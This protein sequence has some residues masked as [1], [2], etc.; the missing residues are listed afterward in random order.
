[1]GDCRE[2]AAGQLAKELEEQYSGADEARRTALFEAAKRAASLLRSR[3]T[4]IGFW[5]AGLALFR[6]VIPIGPPRTRSHQHPL[7]F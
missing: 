5:R 3:Y 1:M 2:Q 4:A 7:S 6:A